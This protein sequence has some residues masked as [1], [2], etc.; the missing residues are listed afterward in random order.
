MCS[1]SHGPDLSTDPASAAVLL[2]GCKE[3]LRVQVTSLL[4]VD[5][6]WI[7]IHLDGVLNFLPRLGDTNAG[8]LGQESGMASSIWL[9][10]GA[11][12]TS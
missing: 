2:H 12:K 7:N 1:S 3:F 4:S 9:Q 10:R 11:L 5:A 8:K 6:E